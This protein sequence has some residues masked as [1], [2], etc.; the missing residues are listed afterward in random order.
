M[1]ALPIAVAWGMLSYGATTTAAASPRSA[2]EET[3]G[4][5]PA[6]GLAL[7]KAFGDSLPRHSGNALTCTSCHLENGRRRTA[8][9]WIGSASR[10]PRF[11]SRPGLE[12]SLPRRINECIARSLA[13]RMLREESRE[14]QD[15]VAYLQQLGKE[16]RPGGVDTVRATGH[17]RRGR[18]SYAQQCARCHAGNGQGLAA[19]APPVWGADSYSIGAGLARQTVLATFLKHNMPY[20]R[21]GSLRDQ[22]AADIAAFIL[23]QPRQDHP[24][25]EQDWPNGDPPSDVAYA[26]VAAGRPGR[27]APPRR[28]LLPRRVPFDSL[29]P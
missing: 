9:P 19:V 8:M 10:Y 27:P 24:G 22:E 17:V 7:L 15:M 13:G 20:D 2:A 12:E 25:K 11:R 14:M 6:R 5:D 29:R 23:T 16:E 18:A 28:P 4:G 26:T 1:L 3:A 21:A